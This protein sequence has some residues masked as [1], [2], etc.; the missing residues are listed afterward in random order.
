[1]TQP[2]QSDGQAPRKAALRMM[3]AVML[4]GK[5]MSELADLTDGLS[6]ADRA[7]AQRLAM[8]TLRHLDK[9]DRVLN[10]YVKKT[11]PVPVMNVLRLATVELCEEAE[12]DHG[13]V[14]S[15]VNAVAKIPRAGHL[16]GLANAVLRKVAKDGPQRWTELP[17]AR[18][19]LW[20]R[21]PLAQAYG[22]LDVNQMEAVWSKPAPLDITL[23]SD[24]SDWAE[25]LGATKL[26]SGSLRLENAGRVTGLEGYDE[27]AWWIQDAAAAMPV[28]LLDPKPN[29]TIIDLCA[30]PGGKTMQLAAS[31]AAVTAVDL[32]EKRMQRVRENLDRT[33]LNAEL[34]VDD[35]LSVAG[36]FDA[37]LLDAPCSATGTLRR[38]PDLPYAKDG[39]EFGALIGLQEAMLDH[40]LSLLKPGGRLVFCTCSLLPDEGECHIDALIERRS[41]VLVDRGA[42]EQD[43]IDPAWRSSEGGLRLRPDFWRESGGMD[44][45]YIAVLRKS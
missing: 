15:A 29:E 24:A 31:G 26:P 7:R 1:M 27:G 21:K 42:L 9:A 5:L 33:G 37:V 41:D 11:P 38:H 10:A 16:K 43:W 25:K 17:A 45:F 39:S 40:S 34:I 35:A 28:R 18:L 12:A 4:Q 8:T 20:L 36:Q 22:K 2:A 14:N 6:P 44:G 23:K 32:S 19:P 30:A 13:V 3:D